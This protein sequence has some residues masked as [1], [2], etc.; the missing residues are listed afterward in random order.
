M[1]NNSQSQLREFAG[2]TGGHQGVCPIRQQGLARP[3][4]GLIMICNLCT[5][6]V[7]WRGQQGAGLH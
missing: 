3:T 5:A 2:L 6:A 1:G 7:S 4:G